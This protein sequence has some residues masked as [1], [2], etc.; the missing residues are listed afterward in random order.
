MFMLC[1]F[2]KVVDGELL[3]RVYHVFEVEGSK[4]YTV[5]FVFDPVFRFFSD[6]G[7]SWSAVPFPRNLVD[8]CGFD[9]SKCVQEGLQ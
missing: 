4:N 2:S 9:F 1:C 8:V 5:D 6:K 3:D 7:Y